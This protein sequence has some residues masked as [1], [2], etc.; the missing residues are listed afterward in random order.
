MGFTVFRSSDSG[1]PTLSGTAGDLL[2]VLSACLVVNNVFTTADDASFTDRSAESRLDAGTAF[3][4]LPTPA[5]GD[6]IYI[7]MTQP[8]SKARFDLAVV[9]IGGTYVWEY[10]NGSAWTT[11][12]VVD[13]TSGFTADGQVTWTIPG[14]WATK[15]VNSVTQ[16]WV[17]I[18]ASANPSTTPTVNSISV[19]DWLE[20]FTGTNQKAYRPNTGNRLYLNV[21]DN[22]P[23][24]GGA[25]EARVVGYETMSAVGTGTNLFPTATQAAN[26]L[27]ARKSASADG[28][29]RSW[30]VVADHRTFY[31]FVLT[32]DISN[33]YFG[34]GF[35][36]VYS[37]VSGS[38][39]WN[40][41]IVARSTENSAV[42]TVENLDIIN[43]SSSGINTDML[44]HYIARRAAGTGGSMPSAKIG[45]ASLTGSSGTRVGM[46]GN[47]PYTNPA[48]GGLYIS[49][50]RWVDTNGG[51]GN[52]IRGRIRGF[53][54][55]MHALG[56][57]ADGDTFSGAGDLA[58]KTFLV[59]K[60]GPGNGA[61]LASVYII[62]TSD[63]LETN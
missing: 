8:F 25:K 37:I 54:H 11:L 6:R 27:F 34:W 61:A 10:W 44:G 35:G 20:A 46:I 57:V 45:D 56:N 15:A 63:T 59:I 18:R 38:D 32:T 14:S 42:G 19:T 31:M 43:T 21:N 9:G 4:L 55:F 7:G 58:G 36:E 26:G 41:M 60:G 40:T 13:G 53:W 49:P 3:A 29:T 39:S 30:I 22:G 1:A 28:T 52:G 2:N 12:T 17:R 47:M 33:T 23:G 62:E 51:S 50:V 24:A 5:S 16:Y 48:D